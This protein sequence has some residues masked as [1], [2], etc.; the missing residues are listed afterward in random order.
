M[1]L[2]VNKQQI[3]VWSAVDVTL[4]FLSEKK[5]KKKKKDGWT[6]KRRNQ[7]CAISGK[8]SVKDYI[9]TCPKLYG[10]RKKKKKEKKEKKKEKKSEKGR[11]LKGR[12]ENGTISDKRPITQ[13]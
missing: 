2:S 9:T 12:N 3:K 4:L 6:L 7:D 5:K 10:L 1:I 11:A 13:G 8:R